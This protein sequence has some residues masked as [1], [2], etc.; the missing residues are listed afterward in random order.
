MK[1]R[2]LFAQKEQLALR[3]EL[4]SL[5]T[6][7]VLQVTTVQLISIRR[8]HAQLV[9]SILTKELTWKDPQPTETALSRPSNVILV[10]LD[11]TAQ[12][13]PHPFLACVKQELIAQQ[14]DNLQFLAT[15]VTIAIQDLETRLHAHQ[16]SIVQEALTS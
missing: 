8:S 2:A 4:T 3:L 10:L 1:I 16:V 7:F 14:E 6:I 12:K 13:K 9:H 5:M 15:Q 11:S